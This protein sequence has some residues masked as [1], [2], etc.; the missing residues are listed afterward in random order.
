MGL[1]NDTES[2]VRA[3]NDY[4]NR[5]KPDTSA[6]QT[7]K[8]QWLTWY[9]GLNAITIKMDSTFQEA[10]NRRNAFNLANQ[11]TPEQVQEYK[12]FLSRAIETDKQVRPDLYKK[13]DSAANFSNQKGMTVL[14]AKAGTVPSGARPT[15]RQG[16]RGAAVSEWQKI[17]GVT[18]DGNFGP[19]TAA[20]TRAWQSARGLEADG[21]VGTATWGA[22]LGAG[23]PGMDL[24]TAAVTPVNP[25]NVSASNAPTGTVAQIKSIKTPKPITPKP[26]KTPSKAAVVAST[27]PSQQVE[28]IVQASVSPLDSI[29]NAPL[30]AKITG[31]VM[32]AGLVGYGLW[33][34]RK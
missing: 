5:T 1:F 23:S 19:N 18:V 33:N 14:S 32:T 24:A 2:D 17:I 25:E 12:E 10:T 27:K 31:G 16:S 28:S 8:N 26:V 30:W 21:V 29:K 34:K 6:A 11:K 4:I 20:A 15:I 7:L 13:A 9:S 3:I 22:A